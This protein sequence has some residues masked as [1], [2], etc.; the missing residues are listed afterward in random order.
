MS[1]Q[2]NLKHTHPLGT[3]KTW[4]AWKLWGLWCRRICFGGLSKTKP[5]IHNHSPGRF[6]DHIHS[7]PISLLFPDG[8]P[9][10]VPDRFPD[11]FP[12]PLQSH[13]TKKSCTPIPSR[14]SHYFP[15][16]RSIPKRQPFHIQSLGKTPQKNCLRRAKRS[17]P[18][19]RGAFGAVCAPENLRRVPE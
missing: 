12:Y 7:G 3:H 18:V 8:F 10:Y 15:P 13:F 16:S 14:Q 2:R 17:H 9:D 6:P 11:P 4:Q 1:S 19:P 5:S